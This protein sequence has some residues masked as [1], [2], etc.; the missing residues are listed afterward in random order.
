MKQEYAAQL[1][2]PSR[3][4]IFV[5]VRR[6]RQ[7]SDIGRQ[8]FKIHRRSDVISDFLTDR[9]AEFTLLLYILS[10]TTAHVVPDGITLNAA[11]ELLK[12]RKMDR[13]IACKNKKVS[14]VGRAEDFSP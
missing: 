2:K 1:E 7:R 10:D 13:A 14:K 8:I 5:R 6:Q 11:V 9:D 4:L 3:I 12:L